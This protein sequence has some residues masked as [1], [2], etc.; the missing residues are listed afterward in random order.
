[1]TKLAHQYGGDSGSYTSIEANSNTYRGNTV[2]VTSPAEYSTCKFTLNSTSTVVLKV[3]S[4]TTRSDNKFSCYNVLLYKYNP[5]TY[6]V[7]D[8]A[9]AVNRIIGPYYM[10]DYVQGNLTYYKNITLSSLGYKAF[11]GCDNL[12]QVELP[13]LRSIPQGCFMGC[14]AL[15]YVSFPEVTQMST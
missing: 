8:M 6:K 13:N 14:S 10:D 1:M 7:G 3:V 15:K 12:S 9:Q 5:R 2:T 4:S 11:A